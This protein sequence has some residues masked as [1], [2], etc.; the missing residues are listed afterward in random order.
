[1]YTRRKVHTSLGE[2]GAESLIWF[3]GLALL[4]E[5]TI[6]LEREACQH[7]FQKN[8]APRDEAKLKELKGVL[9]SYLDTVLKAVELQQ[10]NQSQ[11][12]I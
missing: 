1:M 2:K 3:G 4:S 11:H 10:N 5:V 8:K 12:S 7:T 9:L 6:W